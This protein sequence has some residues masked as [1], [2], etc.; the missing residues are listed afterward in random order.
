VDALGPDGSGFSFVDARQQ[1]IYENLQLV[2][3]GPQAYFRDACILMHSAEGP[4]L[5][6][7]AHLVAHLLR[8][9]ESAL[10]DVLEPVAGRTESPPKN[11]THAW[12]IRG[13]LRALDIGQDEPLAQAWLSIAEQEELGLAWLAHRE[14]LL[15]PRESGP[16][17]RKIWENMQGVLDGILRRF[18]DR[19]A[20]VFQE[21]DRVLVKRVPSSADGKFIAKHIPHCAVALSYLFKQCD[22]PDWLPIL[23]EKGFFRNP[24]KPV[25]DAAHGGVRF[26]PWPASRFLVKMAAHRP[27]EVLA[28]VQ[29]IETQNPW[30]IADL[31]KV[32]LK[33]PPDLANQLVPRLIEWLNLPH[34][35]LMLTDRACNLVTLL[36][37]GGCV[38]SAVALMEALLTTDDDGRQTVHYHRGL[39]ESALPALVAAATGRAV[40]ML[41]NVLETAVSRTS[42]EGMR[43]PP[44]DYSYSWRPAIEDHDQNS[45]HGDIKDFLVE[46]LR[47]GAVQLVRENP[48]EI[49]SVVGS[50]EVRGWFVFQRLAL[51]VLAV[52]PER[53]PDLV[54]QRICCKEIFE[55]WHI[56]H[57]YSLLV[58]AAF[59]K[60]PLESQREVMAWIE[61]GPDAE[62]VEWT[63]SA[64]RQRHQREPN[65]GDIEHFKMIWQARHY[66][67]FG[68]ALPEPWKSEY[69]RLVTELGREPKHADFAISRSFRWGGPGSPKSADELRQMDSHELITFLQNWEPP[70]DANRLSDGWQD[71]EGLG[72]TLSQAVAAAPEG[73]ASQAERFTDGAPDYVPS[74]MTGLRDAAKQGKSF[75]W[76]PV[77]RMCRWVV[78]QRESDQTGAEGDPW[79]V[80]NWRW[81]KMTVLDLLEAGFGEGD[82][83]LPIRLRRD[84]WN[85]LHPLTIDPNPTREYEAEHSGGRMGPSELSSDTVRSRA[86]HAVMR[87][88]L[89]VRRHLESR[90]DG[91]ACT[92]H[93]FEE[94]LE[95]R[96]VL[97]A[98]LDVAAEQSLAVRAVYGFWFP[99]IKLLD[100][101][102][103]SAH[104]DAMFP[105]DKDADEFRRAAWDAYAVYCQPYDDVFPLIERQYARAIDS[106]TT[107]DVNMGSEPNPFSRLAEH[108]ITLYWRG[109]VQKDG[110][111]SQLYEHAGSALRAHV[112]GFVG[113][114]LSNVENGI[115]P[116]VTQ[117]LREFLNWRIQAVTTGAGE[118][119]A[120]EL[121]EFGW[122]IG[123][124]LLLQEEVLATLE[125]VLRRTGKI[126]PDSMVMRRLA[127]L[128]KRHPHRSVTCL[129]LIVGGDREGWT[130]SGAQPEVE[131][132]LRAAITSGDET[133][134][135]TA[136][137]LINRLCAGGH[138]EY[139]QLLGLVGDRGSP[140]QAEGNGNST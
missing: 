88:A 95:V 5:A 98:H 81:A 91:D 50:F 7:R 31:A 24:P 9:I 18:R 94:M 54:L 80:P 47:D 20:S 29:K 60:V 55:N 75:D 102:W 57:E 109:V 129:A 128:C 19:F 35:R 53:A 93:G 46:A 114:A 61:A 106:M 77:L 22:D 108:I 84:V 101:D 78:D 58:K 136:K 121:V 130:I 119:E 8:E 122:W 6:S 96:D 13:I 64:I 110:L 118:A 38:D 36:A 28:I 104:V 65:D 117:R 43:E 4:Q 137:A 1:R 138:V 79:E 127:E 40:E 49:A 68:D 39:R 115:P 11:G 140:P 15:E 51:H 37:N 56:R 125:D 67:L 92:A 30:V 32:A 17:L 27:Q 71:C 99:W 85:T 52:F 26:P 86:L 63:M 87:Y 70:E 3:P 34:N 112:M 103:A 113:R 89:W 107:E 10:R 76:P 42:L 133:T 90:P 123:S 2:G 134:V 72:R 25:E 126:E 83:A 44:D 73:F 139:R 74:V 33:L 69:S 116:E 132:I 66:A 124:D 45:R 21:I 135:K 59:D 120:S 97:D 12:G 62:S 48:D 111:L 82:A 16:S 131:A 14:N 100:C 41:A 105:L 23:E